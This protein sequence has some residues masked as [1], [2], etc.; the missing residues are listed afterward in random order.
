MNKIHSILRKSFAIAVF[1]ILALAFQS[2]EE[3]KII[4]HGMDAEQL[5]AGRIAGTWGAPSNIV[6]PG[7]V[8]AA[9]FGEMRLLFT[10]NSEGRPDK[11][12]AKGCPIVFSDG[13]TDWSVSLT[14][15]IAKINLADVVPVD[16]FKASASSSSLT[17]SFYMGWENTET[18][19]TGEGE[20][21][22]TLR[23]L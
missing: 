22:A 14:E 23:R 3:A 9:V 16:E 13:A 2:C 18:G 6:T 21:S 1:A 11:F 8:P 5:T 4:E 12:S 20:F 15:D 7:N 17:I 19:E 10:T